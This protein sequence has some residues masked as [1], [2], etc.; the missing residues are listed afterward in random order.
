MTERDTFEVRFGAAVHGYAGRI[1]SDLDPLEL[2]HRIAMSEPRRRGRAALMWR[3]FATPG[4]SWALLLV[5]ALLTALVAGILVVGSQPVRKL[6]AVVPPTV[7]TPTPPTVVV[8][9]D[10]AYESADRVLMPDAL[11]IYAPPKAGPLPVVVMFHGAPGS[12]PATDRG[13]LSEHAR[14]VAELG[15]VVFS[16]SWGHGPGGAADPPTYDGLLAVQSQAACAVEYARAHAAEYGGDPATMIMFG[17]SGGAHAAAMVTFARPKPTA[18]CLGGAS[19][20]AINALV[21][22]EGNW[23]LSIN[24]PDWNGAL[25]AD[26]R[27]VD[28]V[29][30]WKYLAAHKDQKVVMLVSEDPNASLLAEFPGFEVERPVGDPWAAGSWLAMRDPSGDLRRQLEANGAFADGTIGFS[31]SQQLLYSVLK[32]QGNLV[33]L[34]VMPDSSHAYLRGAGWDVFLAAFLKAAARD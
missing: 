32:A 6:P 7:I 26:P 21:T 5:A 14:R 10:L 1:S 31:D 27:V 9:R 11:D 4:R 16:A 18:G 34:D 8:T 30:P 13:N 3:A 20:G 28:A 2:A 25:A 12:S 17:H 22:W 33:T 19:L 24:G 29:T 15:F 23:L